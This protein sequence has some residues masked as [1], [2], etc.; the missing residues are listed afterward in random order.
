MGFFDFLFGKKKE[1]H[2]NLSYS[3]DQIDNIIGK[4]YSLEQ[5]RQ[6]PM[7]DVRLQPIDARLV[8]DSRSQEL[9]AALANTSP[10]FKKYLPNMD[11][12]SSTEVAK[13]FHNFYAKTENG[14]EFGYAIKM[15]DD[16]YLGFIF[17]RTPDDNKLGINFPE[18]TIDFCLFEPFRG[19][20]IMLK[21]LSRVLYVLKTIMGVREVYAY[22][23]ESNHKCLKLLSYLPFDLQPEILTDPATGN[24][25]KLFCCPLHSINFHRG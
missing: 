18:W 5:I 25:A 10:D 22:V 12:S 9:V 15:G 2:D 17:I 21:S 3:S 6:V 16:A 4:Y 19:Q 8:C 1:L 7:G 14:Y 24:R 11:L 13:F 23:D 20:G